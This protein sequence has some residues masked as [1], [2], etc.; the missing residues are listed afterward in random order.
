MNASDI[1]AR[2]AAKG[3]YSLGV[4]EDQQPGEGS[5]EDISERKVKRK[6]P[7]GKQKS[8]QKL[9]RSSKS[10]H[11]TEGSHGHNGHRK[12][13]SPTR[14]QARKTKPARTASKSMTVILLQMS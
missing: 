13:T 3:L 12:A 4:G 5:T 6:S 8:V 9:I 2:A 10:S 7:R 11:T 1:L 14:K